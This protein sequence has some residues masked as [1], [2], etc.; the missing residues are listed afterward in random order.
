MGSTHESTGERRDAHSEAAINTMDSMMKRYPIPLFPFDNPTFTAH[1]LAAIAFFA[2]MRLDVE[3][4]G[5]TA[6]VS[7][8][9]NKSVEMINTTY[10]QLA[11]MMCMMCMTSSHDESLARHFARCK[12]IDPLFMIGD[13]SQCQH[14]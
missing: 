4:A 6:I 8:S 1:Q 10:Y 5:T 14:K 11:S 3:V 7:Q 13:P 2:G 9:G 12:S